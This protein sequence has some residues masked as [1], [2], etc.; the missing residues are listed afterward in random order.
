MFMGVEITWNVS[1]PFPCEQSCTHAAANALI[2]G[3]YAHVEGMTR[4]LGCLY[5]TRRSAHL[6]QHCLETKTEEAPLPEMRSSEL[7]SQHRVFGQRTTHLSRT[8]A[9]I[10]RR[11][12]PSEVNAWQLSQEGVRA[13]VDDLKFQSKEGR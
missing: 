4:N 7:F 12:V 5:T 1:S 11:G 13:R 8:S 9:L 3:E 10:S 6:H 2:E